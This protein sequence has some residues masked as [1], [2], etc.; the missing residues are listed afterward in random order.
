MSER[1]LFK[2]FIT[3]KKNE[4]ARRGSQ[5]VSAWNSPPQRAV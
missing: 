2:L 5:K 3:E 4:D 1:T